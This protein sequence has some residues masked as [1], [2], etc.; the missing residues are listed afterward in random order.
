VKHRIPGDSCCRPWL[1]HWDAEH[2]RLFVL[3]SGNLTSTARHCFG[4]FIARP[5]GWLQGSVVAIAAHPQTSP[6]PMFVF[7]YGAPTVRGAGLK[8]SGVPVVQK[9][10]GNKQR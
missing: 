5:V 4:H 2:P 7:L 8:R 9:T 10:R 3:R 6:S 1:P